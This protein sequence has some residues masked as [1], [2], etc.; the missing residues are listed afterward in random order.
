MTAYDIE[1]INQTG[2]DAIIQYGDVHDWWSPDC[3]SVIVDKGYIKVNILMLHSQYVN[4]N[5][6]PV[7]IAKYLVFVLLYL[8]VKNSKLNLTTLL[9][10]SL[11]LMLKS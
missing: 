5:R 6:L 7:T 10:R 4:V 2:E 8:E 9:E 3:P 11:C 1:C